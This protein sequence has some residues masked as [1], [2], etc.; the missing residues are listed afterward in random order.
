MKVGISL[1]I[2]SINNRN[3]QEI[4][5]TRGVDQ[6]LKMDIPDFFPTLPSSALYANFKTRRLLTMF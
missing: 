1:H 5:G 2:N 4:R 6:D 3:Y